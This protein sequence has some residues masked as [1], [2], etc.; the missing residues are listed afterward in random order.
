ME[1]TNHEVMKQHLK[2]R[3]LIIETKMYL[4][5]NQSA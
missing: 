2:S 4:L 5:S 1:Y 3:Y